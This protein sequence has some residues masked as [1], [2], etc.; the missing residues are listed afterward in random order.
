M[1]RMEE[2]YAHLE[3]AKGLNPYDA[4]TYGY[5]ADLLRHEGKFR[6]AIAHLEK[7]VASM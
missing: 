2:A 7:A 6:E 3:R 1:G 5:F 4:V